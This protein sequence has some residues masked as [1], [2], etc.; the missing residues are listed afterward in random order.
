MD[1]LG[2]DPEIGVVRLSLVHYTSAEEV[3]ALLTV[4]GEYL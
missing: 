2:I 1:A 3:D 4:L